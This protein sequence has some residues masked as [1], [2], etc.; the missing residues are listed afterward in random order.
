MRGTHPYHK[1][2]T[3]KHDESLD[4]Y[5]KRTP[6]LVFKVIAVLLGLIAA[7]TIGLVWLLR[8]DKPS[9]GNQALIVKLSDKVN[10]VQRAFPRV[11]FARIYPELS[12][13][14][15]DLLQRECFS[16]RYVY[17][18]FVQF[19]PVPQQKRFVT[20][21]ENGY[22]K[23]WQ[24][25]PWPPAT[26]DFVVFVFGGSTT[27]S[28]GLPDYQT[29]PVMIESELSKVMTTQTIQCYN[30]GRGYYFSTQERILFESLLMQGVIPDVAIFIDGLNDF[31]YADGKPE[32]TDPL[33]RFTAPDMP[34]PVAARIGNEK[35]RADA[36]S[37][38]LS[39]Y[40]H[41]LKMIRA[42]AK[43]YE[44]TPLFVGQPVP[45][46]D[47]IK[48]SRTYPFPATFDGYELCSWGYPRFKEPALAGEFGENFIWCGDAFSQANSV[49]YAD[50]IHY[51]RQ[52]ARLLAQ[53]IVRKALD[54]KIIP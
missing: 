45:F 7:E 6:I 52:G 18:P 4:D 17:K 44:V 31:F 36:V 50:S 54:K 23:G 8:Q 26:N 25:Q 9:G 24:D 16:V 27:F 10:I 53:A 35:E 11:N 49:M 14:D 13:S 12:P 39:Q 47:F 38:V 3:M 51:S 2:Y 37:K 5:R 48:N 22:R 28:Y 46:L 15:I 1:V 41:N 34:E 19:T 21:S 29:L 42:L 20:I 30:F 33:Y 40:G 32:L 43:T